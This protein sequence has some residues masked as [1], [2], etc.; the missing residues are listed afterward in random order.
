MNEEK[1]LHKTEKKKI[2]FA[3]ENTRA[4]FAS[5]M[6]FVKGGALFIPSSHC[7]RHQK[8]GDKVD[9]LICFIEEKEKFV[10]SG[11]I[12]WVTPIGNQG[13]RAAGVGVRFTGDAGVELNDK[14]SSGLVS[15]LNS[16]KATH[17]L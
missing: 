13:N 12:I 15:Q 14:I 16:G 5:Y 10:V 6:P 3:I 1:A 4:L 8:L 11:E 2:S 7:A 9:L 17:T